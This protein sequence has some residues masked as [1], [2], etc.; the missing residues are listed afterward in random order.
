MPEPKPIALVGGVRPREAFR[1]A[2]ARGP[3]L[4]IDRG[5]KSGKLDVVVLPRRD[6]L[7]LIQTASLA[8]ARELE[9]LPA[10]V[11]DA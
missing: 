8:L 6:L 4:L 10:E 5:L 1:G 9:G 7:V 2:P 3:H 11:E